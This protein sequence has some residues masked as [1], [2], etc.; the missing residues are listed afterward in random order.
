MAV[1]GPESTPHPTRHTDSRDDELPFQTRG[2]HRIVLEA[3][4]TCMK[5]TWVLVMRA[6]SE[7]SQGEVVRGEEDLREAMES[8][9]DF[10]FR[11][12]AIGVKDKVGL[13]C[14]R[15]G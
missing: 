2:P 11:A 4:C 1:N 6:K 12:T 3:V 8:R 15:Q 14:G 7:A 5:L 10:A 13:A 9:E